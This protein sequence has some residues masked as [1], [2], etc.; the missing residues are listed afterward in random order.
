MNSYTSWIVSL[1]RQ[2]RD[3]VSE[4][5]YASKR[6][7]ELMLSSSMGESDQAPETYAEFLLRTSVTSIH[8][9]PAC[10]RG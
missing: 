4:M 6:M 3:V 8:E 5:N 9:P 10:R 2:V 7:I 1:V